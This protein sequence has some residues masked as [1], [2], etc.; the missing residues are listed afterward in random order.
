MQNVAFV[1]LSYN[2]SR[3]GDNLRDRR[4]QV[5]SGKEITYLHE[6]LAKYNAILWFAHTSHYPPLDKET[7]DAI[8]AIKPV[9]VAC[10]DA[11]KNLEFGVNSALEQL[12]QHVD[13]DV[14]EAVCD[15]Y[16]KMPECDVAKEILEIVSPNDGGGDDR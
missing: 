15:K 11:I 3:K 10:R 2:H 8:N 5:M 6:L 12:K 14:F 16:E 1:K 9:F 13:W 4:S 7:V